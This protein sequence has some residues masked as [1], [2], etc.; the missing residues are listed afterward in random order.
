NRVWDMFYIHDP[1][2]RRNPLI[3][4]PSIQFE[5]FLEIVNSR[6]QVNPKITCGAL[7]ERFY[8]TFGEFGTPRPRFLGRINNEGTYEML[9][10]TLGVPQNDLSQLD[11]SNV[12]FFKDKF[13]GIYNTLRDS[14][15]KKNP[16]LERLKK[17]LKQKAWGSIIKRVQRYLGLRIRTAYTE[18]AGKPENWDIHKRPPFKTESSVRFVCVDVEAYERNNN[19]V[20]EVGIAILDTQKIVD[21][22]PGDKGE[23]WFKLIEAHHLRVKERSYMVNQEFV[24]GCPDSFHFG[25][26]EFVAESELSRCLAEI[27]GEPN[28]DDQSPVVMVGH[29]VSIDLRY[30]KNAGYNIWILPQYLDEIDTQ[31]MFQRLQMVSQGRSLEL[32]C[33][34][35][36]IPGCNFHNAGNDAVYTLRAMIAMAISKKRG[37]LPA[38]SMPWSPR[39]M[40][41]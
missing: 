33:S 26:P 17:T 24:R 3:F 22:A 28:A 6:L 37:G 38:G 30:L 7:S 12:Q 39:D 27:I 23:D 21:T 40:P 5:Q 10:T 15:K 1:Y 13:D 14:K 2:G 25:T 11:A 16:G 36:G 35:L 34:E 31:L 20:T 19:I 29:D 18:S 9:K 8:V 4:V 32:V 41:K